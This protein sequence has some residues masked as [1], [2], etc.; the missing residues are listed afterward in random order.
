V[1][2]TLAVVSGGVLLLRSE[3]DF[4]RHDEEREEDEMQ[5]DEMQEDEMQEDET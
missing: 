3:W 5:E 4:G 1:L 2:R